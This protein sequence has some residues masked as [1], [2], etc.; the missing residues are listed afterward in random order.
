MTI[1]APINRYAHLSEATLQPAS[2]GQWVTYADHVAQIKQILN[3]LMLCENH[4]DTHDLMDRVRQIIFL[5]PLEGDY[6]NGWTDDDEQSVE[7]ISHD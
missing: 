6:E 7:V 5:P 1:F 4:G 2:N 3:S